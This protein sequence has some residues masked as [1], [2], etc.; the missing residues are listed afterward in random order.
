[1]DKMKTY[2]KANNDIKMSY[3]E[4]NKDQINENA[5]EYIKSNKDKAKSDQISNKD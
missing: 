3:Y 5:K 1:M 2:R 4:S